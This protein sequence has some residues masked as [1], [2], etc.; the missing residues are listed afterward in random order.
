MGFLGSTGG[1]G[2]SGERVAAGP[3][4]PARYERAVTWHPVR[5]ATPGPGRHGNPE[6]PHRCVPP[7]GRFPVGLPRCWGLGLRVEASGLP[8]PGE[9]PGGRPVPLG[10][11]PRGGRGVPGM[12][13][14]GTPGGSGRSRCPAPPPSSQAGVGPG[15]ASTS[16]NPITVN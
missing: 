13:P 9:G 16:P 6:G 4:L 12:D 11:R 5:L 15:V 3:A 7:A 10:S 2:G 8:V 14:R 1:G